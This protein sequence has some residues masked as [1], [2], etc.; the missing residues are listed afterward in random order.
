MFY[1]CGNSWRKAFRFAAEHPS[2]LFNQLRRFHECDSADQARVLFVNV[3]DESLR[4]FWKVVRPHHTRVFVG[5][6][7]EFPNL[8][9]FDFSIG[10]DELDYKGRH[11][12]LHPSYQFENVFP[13]RWVSTMGSLT[14]GK[15]FHQRRFCDF[16]YSNSSAHPMRDDMF[17]ELNRVKPVDAL[18]THNPLRKA[19][20]LSVLPKRT[21]PPPARMKEKV[22]LQMGYRFSIAAENAHFPGYTSEKLI[23]SL[24]AGQVPIY[25]GNPD[26]G[27]DFNSRRIICVEDFSNL[28]ALA[29]YVK[30][31]NANRKAWED[32]VS[33]PWYSGDNEA[34]LRTSSSRLSGFLDRVF[35]S[36]SLPYPIR[37]VGTFPTAVEARARKSRPGPLTVVKDH[38]RRMV[39]LISTGLQ[40]IPW[41]G[42]NSG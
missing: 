7:A 25:W 15:D 36:T 26:I 20:M 11:I 21:A 35:A 29:D 32:I 8:N 23:S 27:Q 9:V 14:G 41:N 13:P 40:R 38:L 2:K 3:T 12:R 18:G 39:H 10:F 28:T 6:E 17:F 31:I 1:I 24:L 34:R 30:E 4:E 37:G 16:I 19:P 42:D 5:A 33:E 22:E